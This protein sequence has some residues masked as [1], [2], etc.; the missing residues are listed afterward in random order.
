MK[1]GI[2]FTLMMGIV[3]TYVLSFMSIIDN[4]DYKDQ[5]LAIVFQSSVIV[6]IIFILGPQV[7][8]IVNLMF[9]K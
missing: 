6:P 5:F 3:A 8:K 9:H 2:V 7:E 4:M 1:Q